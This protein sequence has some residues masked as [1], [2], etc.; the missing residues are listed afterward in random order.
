[1]QR[2]CEVTLEAYLAAG[3]PF[4]VVG[5]PEVCERC[6]G[7]EC[8][9]RNGTY[10]RYVQNNQ[11]KVA[12]FLCKL[13]G[14]T[15][16]LLPAFVLPYRNRLVAEADRFFEA[17]DEQRTQ[18][19]YADVLGQYWRQWVGHWRELQR[20]T[21]WPPSRPVAG[22]PKAHWR[23][24]REAA[25]SI[26]AAQMELIGRYGISLLR[27]YRCHHAPRRSVC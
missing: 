14:L 22:E 2:L 11:V 21:G 9:H 25:G 7:Q 13:C 16:S 4:D 1:M 10:K 26:A 18:I 17:T 5:R 24:L 20:D 23:A 12:R 27:R 6:D 19:S 8:F 15:V 3:N